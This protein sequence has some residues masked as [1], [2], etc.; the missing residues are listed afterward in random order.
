MMGINTLCSISILFSTLAHPLQIKHR[1][2]TQYQA[3]KKKSVMGLKCVI[4]DVSPDHDSNVMM[5]KKPQMRERIDCCK[6]NWFIFLIS[7]EN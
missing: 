3:L 4:G 5:N 7:S 2:N 1:L 6:E